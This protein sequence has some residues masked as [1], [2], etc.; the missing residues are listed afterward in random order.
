MVKC[1]GGER[2]GGGHVGGRLCVFLCMCLFVTHTMQRDHTVLLV[3][4]SSRL[5]I[6]P[7]VGGGQEQAAENGGRRRGGE[8]GGRVGTVN[9]MRVHSNSGRMFFF[10]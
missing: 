7:I 2:G 10:I 5:K 3:C 8:Q 1:I 9:D 4:G 6:G